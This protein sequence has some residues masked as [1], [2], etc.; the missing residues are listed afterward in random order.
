MTNH[1]K[2]GTLPIV[3]MGSAFATMAFA[4]APPAA[5]VP[6]LTEVVVT[7]V[8]ESLQS[9]QAIKRKALVVEDDIVAQ[10]IGKF[11]DNST[12]GAL[13]RVSGVRIRRDADEATT[14]LIRGLPDVVTLLNGRQIF[15]ATGNFVSL[16]DIP[17]SLLQRVAVYKSSTPGMVAGGIA[18]TIE[19]RLHRPF[20][21]PGLVVAGTGQ[22][23]YEGNSGKVDPLGSFLA[24]ERWKTS[25]GDF[26]ALAAFSY[27]RQRYQEDRIFN[28]LQIVG[29]GGNSMPLTVGGLAIPGDRRRTTPCSGDPRRGCSCISRA[30]IPN[31]STSGPMTTSS[32]FRSPARRFPTPCSPARR[33]Y[34]PI[35]DRTRTL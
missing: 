21:F 11:P 19:V 9:A 12:A 15:T 8:R 20:D 26:G 29:P 28:F 10:D 22:A 3:A 32:A 13:Q 16:A 7:G 34:T 1:F 2:Y 18:G 24:S 35:R 25:L 31:T 6:Q 14:V 27:Q 5:K 30:S 23:R 17:A 4:K 33:S